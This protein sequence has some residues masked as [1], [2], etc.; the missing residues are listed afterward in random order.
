MCGGKM[1]R[2]C[3]GGDGMNEEKLKGKDGKGR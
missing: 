2:R 1:S 3:G